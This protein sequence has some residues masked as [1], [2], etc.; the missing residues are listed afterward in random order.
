MTITPRTVSTPKTT[1]VDKK[2]AGY[3][4]KEKE[5]EFYSSGCK[6]LDCVLG[7]G[8]P[9]GRMSNI[10][11]DKSTGKTG[12]A[13]EAC[14]NFKQTYPDKSKIWYFEAESAF[15]KAYAEVLGL[16]VKSI[17]FVN[18]L[19]S[20][21]E[22]AK[23]ILGKESALDNTVET[24]FEHLE[25]VISVAGKEFTRGLYIV[26][27]LDALSD[28][29]EQGRGI[30][31]GTYGTKKA[32]QLSQLFRRLV[33]K[34]GKA[35]IHLLVLSQVR[36]NIGVTFGAKH[37]RSG[38]KALDFYASQ[39]LWLAEVKKHSKTMNK[40]TR[41]IGIQVKAQ[42]KKNKIGMPYRDCEYPIMFAYGIDDIKAHI[43]WLASREALDS[44]DFTP[45]KPEL[46]LKQLPKMG[47]EEIKN[48]QRKLD[49]LVLSEWNSIEEGFLPARSK[50]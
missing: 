5:I 13:I 15:D 6:L 48:L 36:D 24:L 42:C 43:E 44:L 47:I 26:D 31:E 11:G 17:E 38:G 33:D 19:L 21:E 30:S 34:L 39:V 35:N 49:A 46:L 9:I 37:T 20:D 1:K 14:A 2:P 3:F 29:A 40:I 23:K 10:V 28:R 12:M 16:P 4:T 22:T 18:D 7:G 27:S 45:N 8:W 50:Y 41:V 32:A 25:Y